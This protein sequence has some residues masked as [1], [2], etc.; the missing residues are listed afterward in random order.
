M[1]VV[2]AGV[3]QQLGIGMQTTLR[4]NEYTASDKEGHEGRKNYF[5]LP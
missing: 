1:M 2:L 3:G 5:A 4:S